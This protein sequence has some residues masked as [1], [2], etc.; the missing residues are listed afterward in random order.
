MDFDVCKIH[1]MYLLIII[2]KVGLPVDSV[3]IS[4]FLD[5]NPW[6]PWKSKYPFCCCWSWSSIPRHHY[7]STDLSQ[8]IDNNTK[9]QSIKL[10]H[11][12]LVD[13]VSCQDP[14]CWHNFSVPERTLEHLM[15]IRLTM[16]NLTTSWPHEVISAFMLFH[17][18]KLLLRTILSY[19]RGFE[20]G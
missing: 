17:Q 15:T 13:I 6:N 9:V 1:E 7:L 16:T 8:G 3:W 11:W 2:H 19:I 20:I 18:H 14:G 10:S 5:Y 12:W 4:D